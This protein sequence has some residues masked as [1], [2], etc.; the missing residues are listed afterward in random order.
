MIPSPHAG[1]GPVLGSSV[2]GSPVVGSSVVVP[3]P[4]V[5]VPEPVVADEVVG[6]DPVVGIGVPV[7]VAAVVPAAVV[8]SPVPVATV[9]TSSC[10][11]AANHAHTTNPPTRIARRIPQPPKNHPALHAYQIGGPAS[12]VLRGE[13]ARVRATGTTVTTCPRGQHSPPDPR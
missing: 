7:V 11:H 6:T 2:V 4:L 12:R 1:S 3:G 10:P 5:P 8:P 13:P 9:V